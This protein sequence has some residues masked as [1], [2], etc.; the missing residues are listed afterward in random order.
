M[1]KVL[2]KLLAWSLSIALLAGALVIVDAPASTASAECPEGSG[3]MGR[4]VLDVQSWGNQLIPKRNYPDY[5]MYQNDLQIYAPC[6][7]QGEKYDEL[8]GILQQNYTNAQ[9]ALMA[10]ENSRDYK[11][12]AHYQLIAKREIFPA[13]S[14]AMADWAVN[15]EGSAANELLREFWTKELSYRKVSNIFFQLSWHFTFIG[16]LEGRIGE[17]YNTVNVLDKL[18]GSSASIQKVIDAHNADTK[19]FYLQSMNQISNNGI[20]IY[21][22]TPGDLVWVDSYMYLLSRSEDIVMP[23]YYKTNRSAIQGSWT[24]LLGSL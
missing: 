15:T 11:V 1:K 24:A 4:D 8:R 13:L 23:T 3:F 16:E 7:W 19:L 14:S 5:S 17:I 22:P 12:K 9:L 18:K 20:D 21:V 6:Q 2:P 10:A